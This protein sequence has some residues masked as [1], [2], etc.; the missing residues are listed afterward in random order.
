[1]RKV[2]AIAAAALALTFW[3]I[4]GS[5][6][7]LNKPATLDQIIALPAPGSAMSGCFG[8]VSAAGTFLAAG[9]REAT[10][11][12]GVGCTVKNGLFFFGGGLSANFGDFTAGSGSLRAGL[13][14]NPN[15]AIYPVA[16]WEIPDFKAARTGT[17][18]IGGGVETTLFRKEMSGFIEADIGVNKWGS[19]ALEDSIAIRTGIRWYLQ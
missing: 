6:A 5:A 14:I 1:M 12:V 17:L 2:A 15:L 16:R 19:K 10:G 9:P 18:A 11:G 13:F 4:I 3:P 8:E 7:D